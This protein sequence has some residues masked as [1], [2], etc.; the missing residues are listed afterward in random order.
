MHAKEV[1]VLWSNG[2]EAKG[3][4]DVELRDER[5][6]S[7]A[8]DGVHGVVHGDVPKREVVNVDSVID[9]MS[10]WVGKVHNQAPFARALFGDRP[11]RAGDQVWEGG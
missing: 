2:A 8:H 1:L 3:A 7:P 11:K 4:L 9:A 5:S 6:S 10:I